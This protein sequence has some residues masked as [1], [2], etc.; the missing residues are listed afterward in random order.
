MGTTYKAVLR[1]KMKTDTVGT[2]KIRETV[3]TKGQKGLR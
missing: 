3:K 2:L 1:V